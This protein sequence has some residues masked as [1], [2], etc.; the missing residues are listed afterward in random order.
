MRKSILFWLS[1]CVALHAGAIFIA[2]QRNIP[3]PIGYYQG[4]PVYATLHNGGEVHITFSKER[5]PCQ[6]PFHNENCAYIPAVIYLK[7]L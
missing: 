5:I 4:R 2:F 7:G 6:P 1:L 3:E